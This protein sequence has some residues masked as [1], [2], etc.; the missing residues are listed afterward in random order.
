MEGPAPSGYRFKFA[1]AVL[2]ILFIEDAAFVLK[3]GGGE[4][5]FRKID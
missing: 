4:F 2:E 3:Q 1:G 5:L